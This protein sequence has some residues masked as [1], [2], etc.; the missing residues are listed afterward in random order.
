MRKHDRQQ[1][2]KESDSGKPSV[3]ARRPEMFLFKWC[4]LIH[5]CGYSCHDLRWSWIVSTLN[6]PSANGGSMWFSRHGNLPKIILPSVFGGISKRLGFRQLCRWLPFKAAFCW[7]GVE[8]P[9]VVDETSAWKILE[10]QRFFNVIFLHLRT[11][12]MVEK[13]AQILSTTVFQCA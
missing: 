11:K 7:S 9:P 5:G 12:N 3:W 2:H 8:H 13:I 4:K 10:E 6:T 1:L